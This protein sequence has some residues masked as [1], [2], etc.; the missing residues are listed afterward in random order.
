MLNGLNASTEQFLLDVDRLQKRSE[1]AQR[2]LTSGL[3]VQ[4]VSDSPDDVSRLLEA[5][6]GIER[7][8]QTQQN[9]G[10]VKTEVDAAEKALE[11]AVQLMDR[12][13]T[14]STQGINGLASADT[15]HQL[16]S[17]MQGLLEQMVTIA[18]TA[19]EG[20]HILSGDNDQTPPYVLDLTTAKGVGDYQ[21]TETLRQVADTSGLLFTCSQSADIIFDAA[22]NTQNV[23]YA[24]NGM[25]RALLAVDNPPDIPDPTIPTLD[26][27]AANLGSAS[28]YLNQRLSQYGLYQNRVTEAID[29]GTKMQ[30]SLKQQVANLEEADLAEA[31]TELSQMKIHLDA[32]YQTH[33]V[34]S[35]KSLF[36]YIG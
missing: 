8:K 7:V 1:R 28:Q 11:N 9:L 24:I 26:Q 2:R 4:N 3:K 14:L 36:D 31:A 34:A 15:R 33:A 22:D 35:R 18:G 17:E 12:A 25:R 32:A 30:L 29:T 27:A 23:F 16:A 5:R 20:R 13:R 21:G 19:V 10:R 6:A